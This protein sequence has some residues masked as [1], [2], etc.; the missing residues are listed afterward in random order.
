MNHLTQS[1]RRLAAAALVLLSLPVFS[2]LSGTYT[3]DPS[4][5]GTTNYASFTAAVSALTTSGVSGP[6]TFNVAAGTY[7]EQIVIGAITGSSATNRVTFQ[8]APTATGAAVLTFA[9]TSTAN[10]TVQLTAASNLT[11]KDLTLAN[12]AATGQT[13]GGIVEYG[14]STSNIQFINNTFN[15]NAGTSTSNSYFRS[16]SWRT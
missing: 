14:G 16:G 7:S 12:T 8:K 4:G 5:T 2:Q 13:V 10:Y 9:A 1:L 15:G 11:F 3:I 6:V